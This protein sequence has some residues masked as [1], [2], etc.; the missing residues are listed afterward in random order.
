MTNEWTR[1][2]A[3]KIE[4][5]ETQIQHLQGVTDRLY[6][7]IIYIKRKQSNLVPEDWIQDMDAMIA[8]ERR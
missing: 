4:E 3:G 2:L 7:A 1:H 5:I 8:N 6:E